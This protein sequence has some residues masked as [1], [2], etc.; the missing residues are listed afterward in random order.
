[1]DLAP[2]K[3]AAGFVE[4][5]DGR[6][7]ERQECIPPCP[8]R[9]IARPN[10]TPVDARVRDFSA[11]GLGLECEHPF[12][13]GTL[14]AVQIQKRHVGLSGLLTAKVRHVTPLPDGHWLLGCTLSRSL[15]DEE[16]FSLSRGSP[17][18]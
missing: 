6:W 7:L 5:E 12:P 2:Q 15:N 13:R 17:A 14:L 16:I 10:L 11:R 8:V 9:L 4:E 1:M 3:H 18:R